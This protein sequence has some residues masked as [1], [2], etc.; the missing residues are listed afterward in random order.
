MAPSPSPA[1]EDTNI[2]PHATGAAASLVAA[3]SAEHPLKLYAGWFC[4][5]VQRAWL[6]LEE[7]RIPYQYVEINPYHKSKS[8][9]ELNPRGLVPTLGVP[10]STRSSND[11]E[12]VTKPLYESTVICEYLDEVYSD[13]EK[14]GP[15]LYPSDAYE[16][17]RCRIWV[18]HICSR[19]VPS[20]YRFCQHQPDKSYSIEEVRAEFLGHLRTFITEADE[21]GPFFLGK[22][23]S[24]VDVM[25]APWLVRLWILDHFKDGGLGMPAKGEAG[26]EEEEKVWNRWRMWADAVEGRRSVKETLSGREQYVD[27]YRR[28]AE[29]KTQSEVAKA[30]RSGRN[31][32]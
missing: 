22:E 28:Y 3:H 10:K 31:L 5:F 29:D 23:F 21:E 12:K 11:K 9:L 27:V 26:S 6:V 15:S 20:F 13:V 30:T 24:M 25:L 19:I 7:K 32:P 18:D 16:R 8:F 2:Y 17:A 14:H 4:P 1:S